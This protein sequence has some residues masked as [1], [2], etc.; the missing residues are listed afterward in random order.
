MTK[1]KIFL[2]SG[3]GNSHIDTDNW[4]AWVRD[5][6]KLRGLTWEHFMVDGNPINNTFTEL[7]KEME[8]RLT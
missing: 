7:I 2:F 8:V 4:Y 3:N 1:P 5:E 6:L